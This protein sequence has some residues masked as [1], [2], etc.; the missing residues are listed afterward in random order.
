MCTAAT[1]RTEDHYF[2]RTL[3]YDFSYGEEVVI[4]P[5]K[6]R[7]VFRN[8]PALDEPNAIRGMALVMD[9][10]PLYFEGINEKGVGMAGLN[11]VHN[12]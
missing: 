11:F 1:Y 7:L 2:G 8:A 6:H 3:D 4:T 12:A 9:G 10:T 5:R